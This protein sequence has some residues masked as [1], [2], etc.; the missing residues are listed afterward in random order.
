[1]PASKNEN[2]CQILVH[3]RKHKVAITVA[4]TYFMTAM[5]LGG[6]P[7]EEAGTAHPRGPEPVFAVS[8]SCD[9]H[10]LW[11]SQRHDGQSGGRGRLLCGIEG[12][13]VYLPPSCSVE[14]KQKRP[15]A[16]AGNNVLSQ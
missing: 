1:M 2:E 4:V 6:K 5:P 10:C 3:C 12:A 7:Q 14:L 13:P 11:T 15:R 9:V 8:L 16:Y